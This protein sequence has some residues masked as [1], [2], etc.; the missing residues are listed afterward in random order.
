MRKADPFANGSVVT[1]DQLLAKRVA[2]SERWRSNRTR[3]NAAGSQGLRCAAV[4]FEIARSRVQAG[5]SHLRPCRRAQCRAQNG[6]VVGIIIGQPSG[7]AARN[8]QH[9]A[10]I[11]GH[12]KFLCRDSLPGLY[13]RCTVS[14]CGC[15]H[16]GP[17]GPRRSPPPPVRRFR[18]GELSAAN[19][20]TS[21]K[22]PR[23]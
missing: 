16:S 6:W 7:V 15:S 4:S 11:E 1:A 5:R 19:F 8:S 10:A 20:R 9:V 12:N 23:E 2:P 18:I 14:G 21:R 22:L 3:Q 17:A 13:R